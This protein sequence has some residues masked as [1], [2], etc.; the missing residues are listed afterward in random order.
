MAASVGTAAS[1]LVKSKLDEFFWEWLCQ[2]ES[3]KIVRQAIQFAKGDSTSFENPAPSP[4]F[5]SFRTSPSGR[6]SPP[7]SPHS[8]GLLRESTNS[9]EVST[10]ATTDNGSGPATSPRSRQGSAI[11]PAPARDLDA[12]NRPPVTGGAAVIPRFWW[13][14]RTKPTETLSAE[15][16]LKIHEHFVKQG[17]TD[18]IRTHTQLEPI[19]TEV[20]SLSKYFV[21]PIFHK[22]KV[23]FD[24]ID[25]SVK[26]KE[27]LLKPSP[28]PITEEMLITWCTGKIQPDDLVLSFYYVVKKEHNNWI[29]R[30]DFSIFL[31]TIL[32]THPGLDFLRETQEFQDRYAD[33]V[34]SRIF[35]VYDQK[36]VGRIYLTSLRR[37]RPSVI[38]TWK[39]LADH[40]DIKMVRDYFSYEHFYVIYC[41]FWE[42]DTDHDFLLDKDDLLKYD[43]HALSRRTV[44]RIFSETPTKFTSAVPGKMGYEDFIR[45]LLCD[46]DRQT[47]RSMEY[48]FHMFDLDGDGCIRD[49]EMKYFYE[50]Q[51][52][53]MECLSY[54]TIPFADILCQM[55]DM[56]SPTAEGRF[57]LADFKKRRKFAGTF[58]ALFSSLNKF[59]AFEHRDPFS[60][61]QEQLEN[62]SYSDWDRW[63]ADEY[64]RLAME[65]GED[66]DGGRVMSDGGEDER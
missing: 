57:K 33:T 4:H 10:S 16:R 34:I 50:E 8:R 26:S 65:E 47:D 15:V 13:P 49:H 28:E 63:C 37:Y 9:S 2:P 6:P 58:F 51:A 59:L 56:I 27:A 1:G 60:A 62:P 24:I 43:G 7:G 66:D 21:V 30:E 44:D 48:W 17:I 31:L 18:G 32:L 61:K 20:F 64:L 14:K 3:Q 29:E 38:E 52:Q 45:F 55:N 42:L 41:T 19:I 53:R 5:S 46:Q 23:F 40:D 22:L 35:F 36:D 54:D 25:S 12:T 39:Q 11:P